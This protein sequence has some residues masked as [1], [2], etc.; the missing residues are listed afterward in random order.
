MDERNEKIEGG[1]VKIKL[2]VSK[3]FENF[4]YYYKWHTLVGLFVVFASAIL[5]FQTCSRVK[6][7]TY[8]LYAGTHTVSRVGKDGNLSE[9]ES[10]LSSFKRVCKDYNEDGVVAISF[11]DL[12]VVNQS[13]AQKLLDENPGMEI[14]AALVQ[15]DSETLKQKLVVGEYYLCFLSERLFKEYEESYEGK[16][17]ASISPYTSQN[18]E[19]EY[20]S[21][22]GIYLR[23][24]PFSSLPEIS[25]LPDDTVVCIRKFADFGMGNDKEQFERSEEILKNILSY[26]I[27]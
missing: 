26:G 25:D 10:L 17:F 21:D 22:T 3:K 2:P 1:E 14:N 9:Y 5:I 20:C 4:W 8:I 19:Y 15:E 12:F 27:K 24:L 6:A 13:E 7:D 23:S 16:L 18:G 11:L